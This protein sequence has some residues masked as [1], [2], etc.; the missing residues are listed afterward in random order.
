MSVCGSDD[1]FFKRTFIL[2]LVPE[3]LNVP[4]V[5]SLTFVTLANGVLSVLT[6]PRW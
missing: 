5:N 2:V 4:N 6:L 3:K 1:R